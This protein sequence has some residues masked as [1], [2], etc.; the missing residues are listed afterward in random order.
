MSPQNP[1]VSPP[2]LLA[3]TLVSVIP[4]RV[5]TRCR[6]ISVP[7]HIPHI[8]LPSPH[9]GCI[10]APFRSFIFQPFLRF[11]YLLCPLLLSGH[12]LGSRTKLCSAFARNGL[13]DSLPRPAVGSAFSLPS[14]RSDF[15][16]FPVL[17]CSMSLS[18]PSQRYFILRWDPL[19]LNDLQ[20]SAG[21]SAV[22]H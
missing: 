9:I 19:C 22:Y 2:P 6:R 20:V 21:L 12:V 15:L 14:L 16:F 13:P 5:F 17:K 8:L 11:S 4:G 10:C 3:L 7:L 18:I 1:F